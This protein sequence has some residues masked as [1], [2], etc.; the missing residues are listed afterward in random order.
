[1][2]GV[3]RLS[4]ET[5]ALLG[6]TT[7][8]L[9]G[10]L[11]VAC[12]AGAG[13]NARASVRPRPTGSPSA[14]GPGSPSAALDGLHLR[15]PPDAA[16]NVRTGYHAAG[17]GVSDDTAAL[18]RALAQAAGRAVY[19]PAGRYLVTRA[20]E[21]RAGT[22]VYGE[23]RSGTVIKLADGAAGF[24][25]R[26]APRAAL[27][28]AA[29]A[30]LTNLSVDTGR[31]AG[32]IGIDQLGGAGAALRRLTVV[33]QGVAGV[34][35][36]RPAAGPALLSR[37]AVGGFD[38][39]VQVGPGQYGLTIEHLA[40]A[41]QR[42]AGLD[43][44][45]NVLAVRD[46]SSNNRVPAV[47]SPDRLGLVTLVDAALSG[48][49]ATA[50]AIDSTGE[51][52]ARNVTTTGYRSAIGR[53]ASVVAG[54]RVTEYAS[55]ARLALFDRVP[56]HSL[57]LPVSEPVDALDADPAGWASV[58]SYGALADDANDDTAA[59]Q[60]AIDSGKP[61]IYLPFGRYLV[62]GT[63]HLRGGVRQLLGLGST[64][65]ASGPAFAD[66]RHPV[67]LVQADDGSAPDVGVSAL[68]VAPRVTTAAASAGLVLFTQHT[69]RPLVLRD[70]AGAGEYKYGYQPAAGAGALYLE[71]VSASRWHLDRP[72]PVWARQLNPE[73]TALRVLNTAATLWILGLQTKGN[74]PVLRTEGA[75]RTEL[76]GGAVYEAG[77]PGDAV[78]ECVDARV[79]LSFATLGRDPYVYRVLVRQRLDGTSRE[80]ARAQA[81]ARAGGRS[82]PLY[83]G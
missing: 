69:A 37:L 3:R 15:L 7:L 72:Q 44:A 50:S 12:V 80:L 32:A 26:R 66:A 39:A 46:L 11:A 14:S 24:G 27:R 34:A 76:L 33:G 54:T 53:G 64:L 4:T 59:I 30:V 41:G 40:I 83:T 35:M 10:A 19:L 52:M 73:D 17:D 29:G 56:G 74:A 20:L 79:T 25:D 63:L 18:Q 49:S 67:P 2:T 42:V 78:F 48:G 1:M 62:S 71:N 61:V 65:L 70:I 22:A 43:N 9:V 68:H 75:G 51:L 36:T 57:G 81:A 13:S 8:S 6:I 45:G 77:R 23:S 16:L 82:V 28:T 5:T 38:Y 58:R 60:R 55:G 31:N 47:H 21:V